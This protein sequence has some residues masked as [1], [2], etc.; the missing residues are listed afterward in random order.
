MLTDSMLDDV[1]PDEPF[2]GMMDR[3]THSILLAA[4]KRTRDAQR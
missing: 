3:R 4:S 1:V 2:E